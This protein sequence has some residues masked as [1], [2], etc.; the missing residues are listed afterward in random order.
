MGSLASI[1]IRWRRA[2]FLSF[3]I[4]LIASSYAGLHARTNR[5]DFTAVSISGVQH[6]GSK[7]AIS[8]FYVNGYY[9][10]N[11]AR[12]GG[13][14]STVCCAEIP[15][16]WHPGLTAEVRWA[17]VH[18]TKEGFT[19]DG[20]PQS[21]EVESVGTYRAEVP[22]EKYSAVGHVW[23]HFFRDGQVRIVISSVGPEGEGHPIQREDSRA[24][25]AATHGTLVEALFSKEEIAEKNRKAAQERAVHGDWR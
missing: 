3:A 13:G 19:A 22:I 2:V 1:G 21:E 25:D 12:N 10:S 14:G 18:W 24:A 5:S 20:L 9:A 7:Y 4:I 11:I 6:L 23:V 8:E 17:V 15:E 16:R